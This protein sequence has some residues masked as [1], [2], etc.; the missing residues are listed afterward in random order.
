MTTKSSSKTLTKSEMARAL[1]TAELSRNEEIVLRM[2]HG[3]SVPLNEPLEMMDCGSEELQA[4]LAAME[5][6]TLKRFRPL[7]PQ[8]LGRYHES[9]ASL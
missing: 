6:S 7:P 1:R 4:R 2:R 8:S 3:I 5:Q 9:F